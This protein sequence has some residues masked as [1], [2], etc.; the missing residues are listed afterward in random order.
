MEINK[1]KIKQSENITKA[2][3]RKGTTITVPPHTGGGGN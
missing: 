1:F 2:L 3:R